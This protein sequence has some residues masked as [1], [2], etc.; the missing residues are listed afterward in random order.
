M[1]TRS[2]EVILSNISSNL[3]TY[4]QRGFCP[5]DIHADGEF[6]HTYHQKH[7][8]KVERAIRT[9][10]DTVRATIHG[11]PYHHIPRVLV[12]ELVSMAVRTINM[13]PH[14]DGISSTLSPSTIVTGL[15]R[16]DY[17]T[18]PLEFGAYVQVYDGTS[19]NTKSRTM[20]AI[21]TNP[22]GNSSGD[23]F[24]MSIETG[25]RIHRR[26]WTLLPVS[27]ATISLVEALALQ[28]NMPLI[29]NDHMVHEYDPDDAVDESIF[30]RKQSRSRLTSLPRA[31]LLTHLL[32]MES[33]DQRQYGSFYFNVSRGITN[34]IDRYS[35]Q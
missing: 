15:P 2:K 28:Q 16:P 14:A 13:L 33:A 6:N 27:D 30:D 3:A 4:R 9:I 26:S 19:I 20:G 35:V 8:P 22:T 18:M 17:N 32:R 7:V 1:T 10:K 31:A 34:I 12:Q 11:L 29:G 24:F 21:A 5:T 25:R 23:H